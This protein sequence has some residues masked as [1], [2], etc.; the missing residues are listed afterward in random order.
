MISPTTSPVLY[1][2]ETLPVTVKSYVAS[3]LSE[4]TSAPLRKIP[5]GVEETA[6]PSDG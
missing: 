2:T 6:P 5:F 3:P 1:V 4:L